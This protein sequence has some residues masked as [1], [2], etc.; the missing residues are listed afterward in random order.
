MPTSWFRYPMLYLLLTAAAGVVMR[1]MAFLPAWQAIYVPLLHAHSHLALLGW[2]YTALILLLVSRLLP[3]QEQHSRFFH[4]N[5][6]LTQLTIIAMFVSFILQGYGLF[7]ILFSTVHIVLSYLLAYWIWR[8]LR[9]TA[10]HRMSILFAKASLIFMVL[11]SAGP[12]ALAVLSARHLTE[13]AWYHAAL[14]FYLHCQYNGWFTLGLF[15]VL[16]SILEEK[17]TRL[18]KRL[19]GFHYWSYTISLL[20][21]FILSLLWMELSAAWIMIAVVAGM[22]QLA[23]I[24]AFLLLWLR[25]RTCPHLGFTGWSRGFLHLALTSLIFKMVLELG[26]AVPAFMPLVF[27]TRDIIIGYLHLVLLGFVSGLPLAFA[28]HMNWL[29][30]GKAAQWGGTLFISGFILNEAVLFLNGLFQWT[31]S[32][33]LPF[34]TLWLFIAS[35]FMLPGIGVLN[36]SMRNCIRPY[37]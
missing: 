9:V 19:A 5:W 11:S 28:F 8:R 12:W 1:G 16:Y 29:K 17:I 21:S 27:A 37:R 4:I 23:S 10:V 33:P 7:S 2:G 31:A 6:F 3:P 18:P 30:E 26:S 32:I 34:H 35:L 14:Y 13:S 20:P 22:L 24:A 15:A 25:N 36:W